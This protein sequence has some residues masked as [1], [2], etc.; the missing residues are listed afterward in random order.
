MQPRRHEGHKPISITAEDADH[1][2]SRILHAGPS[3]SA[4][5]ARSALIVIIVSFV[6]FVVTPQ[7]QQAQ[8]PQRPTFSSSTRLIVQTVTVKDKDGKPIEGLTAKDFV[9]TEDG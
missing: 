9:V 4:N 8:A 3:I 1:T 5:S 2:E 6:S 7:A